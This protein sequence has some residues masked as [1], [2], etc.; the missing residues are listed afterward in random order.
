MKLGRP[1]GS[2]DSRPRS[3][4]L[5]P[6]SEDFE[7]SS[8]A[9][10]KS[11]SIKEDQKS[12]TIKGDASLRVCVA[13]RGSIMERSILSDV[14]GFA[15][16]SADIVSPI[17][18]NTFSAKAVPTSAQP[19]HEALLCATTSSDFIDPFHNDWQFWPKEDMAR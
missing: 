1:R 17:T 12:L 8:A 7:K 14:K 16:S 9:P 13:N 19:W 15:L 3:R 6:A 18:P 11:S 4:K 5:C 2:K 10:R